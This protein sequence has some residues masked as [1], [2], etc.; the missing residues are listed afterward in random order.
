M[1]GPEPCR[2]LE[3]DSQHFGLRI[4][5]VEGSGFDAG[6]AGGVVSWC[7]GKSIDCVYFLADGS[8]TAG[9]RLAEENGFR[10]VDIRMTL[11]CPASE[12]RGPAGLPGG[13]VRPFAPE[14]LPRLREIARES[15]T[16]TR[17]FRD[18]GFVRARAEEMYEIWITKCCAGEA[19]AVFVAV[20]E[21][22]PAGYISCH[23]AEGSPGKIGLLAVAGAS[24]GRGLGRAL[25]DESLGWFRSRGSAP[26]SV[27][28]QG[29][30]LPAVRLYQGRGFLVK[31]VQLWFHRWFSRPGGLR[32]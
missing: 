31:S 27:V 28:T 12:P 3:W 29:A 18:G 26:V 23:Q 17:F 1:S 7:Q 8:D 5:Q 2:F 10:L 21:G 16:G 24:Q 6:R 20:A 32:S 19:Q 14:D 9:V 11:E 4:A 22:R 13:S 25:L 15:H 30:S